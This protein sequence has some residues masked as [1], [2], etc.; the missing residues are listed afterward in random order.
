[1]AQRNPELET[2]YNTLATFEKAEQQISLLFETILNKATKRRDLLLDQLNFMKLEYLDKEE[3][4]KKQIQDLEQ[5]IE[6]LNKIGIQQNK[7]VKLHEEH[8]NRIRGELESFQ[9]PTTPPVCDIN[10]ENLQQILHQLERIGAIQASSVP[11]Q[12]NKSVKSIGKEGSKDGELKEPLGICLDEE[13]NIYVCDSG[14]SR[15]QVF[16]K[17][18]EFLVEFGGGQLNRPYGIALYDKWVLLSDWKLDAVFKFQRSGHDLII[19]SAK[20]GILGPKGLAVDENEVFVADSNNHRIAILNL[21]LRFVRAVGKGKLEFPCDVKTSSNQVFVADKSKSHNV[22]VFSKSA[23]LLY[24]MISLKDETAF[25]SKMFRTYHMFI[26]FS[27]SNIM[28]SDCG[29]KSILLYTLDG[30]FLQSIQCAGNPRGLAVTNN[31]SIV[32]ATDNPDSVLFI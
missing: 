1:M 30:Q 24:S 7:I 32:Y 20:V 10:T 23:D 2:T 6:Q 21:E 11:I 18:G 8:L 27:Q 12:R 14:N 25:L 13:E 28:V 3:V 4:R 29:I 31:N 16:R 17:E 5:L 19:R 22:H 26:C 9:T 15:I